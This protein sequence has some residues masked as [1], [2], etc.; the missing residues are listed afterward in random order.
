VYEC[1]VGVSIRSTGQV[2]PAL[3]IGQSKVTG[4]EG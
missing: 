1:G 2:Q 3:G 4:R